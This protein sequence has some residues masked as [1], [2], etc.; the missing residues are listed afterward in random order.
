[1]LDG[2]MTKSKYVNVE[3][4]S[5]VRK[6]TLKL[7]KSKYDRAAITIGTPFVAAANVPTVE[8]QQNIPRSWR[9]E[10]NISPET[11]LRRNSFVRPDQHLY[12]QVLKP[13]L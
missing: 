12:A 8:V 9:E 2:A 6:L 5:S 13:L 1:M 4:Y 10:L 11:W 3:Q 7:P